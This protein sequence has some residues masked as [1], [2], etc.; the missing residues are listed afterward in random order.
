MG[1]LEAMPPCPYMED[2]VL[3]QRT[4]HHLANKLKSAF[5]AFNN[6]VSPG[7]ALGRQQITATQGIYSLFHE[8]LGVA[9]FQFARSL[10][11]IC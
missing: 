7:G 3:D 8:I 10:F 5:E 6:N 1:S 4:D 2:N 9:Y 11:K